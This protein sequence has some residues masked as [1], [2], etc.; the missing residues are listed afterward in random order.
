M[1]MYSLS[2]FLYCILML[3]GKTLVAQTDTEKINKFLHDKMVEE[4]IP[5]LQIVVIRDNKI[6]LSEAMGM[7]NIEFSVPVTKNTLFS[8]NSIAKVFTGTAVM[9]LVEEGKINIEKPVRDYLDGLPVN[10]QPVTLRQ[11]LGHTSGIPDIEDESTGGL[12]GNKGE[13]TAWKTV[14]TMPMQFKPGER[15]SYNAT[16]YLLLQKIIEKQGKLPFEQFIQKYQLS[17]VGMTKTIF[18][19]SYEVEKDKAPTYCYYYLDRESG[20]HVKGNQLLETDENFPK[21]F[22]ADTGMYST[23]EEMAQWIIALQNNQ[24]LKRKESI[25][26]M[27]TPVKLTNGKIDGFGD[28]LNGYAFGW[29]VVVRSK[30][31]AVAPIGGGRAAF[32]IYP[33]DNLSII[34]LTNLS[35]CSPE[36]IIDQV[37]TMYFTN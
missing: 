2:M 30:H 5:G 24:L 37:A 7:A 27:W 21:I 33:E 6:V 12:V 18:G 1:N 9:H 36:L 26:M 19:N 31:P 3:V 14:Q 8:I 4:H 34:L 29:P 22:R 25:K 23:A 28:I 32:M 20:E 17:P 15:F 13:V 10:W 16:N 35:G 11:L